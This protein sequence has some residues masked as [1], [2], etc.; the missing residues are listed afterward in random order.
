VSGRAAEMSR[1][2]QAG[3]EA[4][5]YSVG[6]GRKGYVVL[7]DDAGLSGVRSG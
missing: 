7:T 1:R 2:M 3:T 4:S 6:F 5:R